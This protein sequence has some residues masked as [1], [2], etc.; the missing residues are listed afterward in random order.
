MSV[1][2][3]SNFLAYKRDLNRTNIATKSF[4][5]KHL[6]KDT[7]INYTNNKENRERLIFS[8]L[9]MVESIARAYANVTPS[10]VEFEDLLQAGNIGAIIAADRWLNTSIDIR[11]QKNAKFSTMCHSWILKYVKEHLS[12]SMSILSHGVT[13]SYDAATYLVSSGDAC[14]SSG[15]DNKTT[16]FEMIA[17]TTGVDDSETREQLHFLAEVSQ[18]MFSTLS[19]KEK[20]IVFAFFGIDRDRSMH[21]NEISEQLGI[22][23]SATFTIINDCMQRMK[24]KVECEELFSYA[25][26]MFGA[27]LSV[28]DEWKSTF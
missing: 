18:K 10:R 21:L 2:Y 4:I 17:N 13:K 6:D 12:N 24:E 27:D 7:T 23:K 11:V 25:S 20:R 19:A 1:E 28:L 8:V 15:D 22:S 5:G 14:V 26:F 3:T 16:V 9:P